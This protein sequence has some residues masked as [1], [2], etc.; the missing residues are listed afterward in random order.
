V[1][2]QKPQSIFRLVLKEVEFPLGSG[3]EPSLAVNLG[4]ILS[5][6]AVTMLKPGRFMDLVVGLEV[7]TSWL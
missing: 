2:A 3:N 4:G 7:R 5:G 6:R 1:V